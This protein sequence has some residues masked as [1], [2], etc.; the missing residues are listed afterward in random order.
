[1][2]YDP[3]LD[4][5]YRQVGDRIISERQHQNEQATE[6]LFFLFPV[7]PLLQAVVGLLAAL[8]AGVFIFQDHSGPWAEVSVLLGILGVLAA[9]MIAALFSLIVIYGGTGVLVYWGTG[10]ITL[11]IAVPI[12][13]AYMGHKWEA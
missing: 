3:N 8:A 6:A 12:A 1:M 5:S 11:T 9:G 2:S 13:L 4:N 10:S 7:H